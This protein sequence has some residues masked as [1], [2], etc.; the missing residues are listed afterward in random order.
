M[1]FLKISLLLLLS[2][3]FLSCSKKEENQSD[4]NKEKENNFKYQ[5]EQFADLGILRYK[6][7]GFK[8]LSQKQKELV[9]YLYQ[10]ALSGRDIFYDQNYAHNLEIRRTLEAIVNSYDGK[11]N[12]ETTG[13]T[14]WFIQ[15]VSGSQTE[16][17]II[18]PTKNFSRNFQK[19]IS[20]HLL[21]IPLNHCFLYNLEKVSIHF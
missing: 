1:N 19:N 18:T 21:I 10:A 3:A 5:T 16:Y 17:I 12:R 14:L 15:R 7:P 2:V 8:E 9:Y 13:I 20:L 4:M 6:V 11:R